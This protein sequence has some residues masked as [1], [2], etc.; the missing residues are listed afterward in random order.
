MYHAYS[1]SSMAFCINR[2]HCCDK[3]ISQE[4]KI[5][6]DFRCCYWCSFACYF[7]IYSL[8]DHQ[9][10]HQ[11]PHTMY[12]RVYVE[13]CCVCIT[14]YCIV[15]F[16]FVYNTPNPKYNERQSERGREWE[17]KWFHVLFIS[18]HRRNEREKTN[19][20]SIFRWIVLNFKA[21]LMEYW[22]VIYSECTLHTHKH[23]HAHKYVVYKMK[24][25]TSGEVW[26]NN[27]KCC[28]NEIRNMSSKYNSCIFV[29]KHFI[30]VKM[31]KIQCIHIVIKL[32]LICVLYW[33]VSYPW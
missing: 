18:S 31:G 33:L 14:L 22:L 28:C 3:W 21:T 1:A 16:C 6:Y 7:S 30:G 17:N 24:W 19:S 8:F 29:C 26:I 10:K 4:P 15:L 25:T 20:F 12:T 13:M 27:H 23:T 9:H 5:H 11:I 32:A 2:N